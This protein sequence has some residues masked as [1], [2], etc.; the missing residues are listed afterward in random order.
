MQ[1][2]SYY[3]LVCVWSCTGHAQPYLAAN[4]LILG[5][6]SALLVQT[7][8]FDSETLMR[9]YFAGVEAFSEYLMLSV[10]TCARPKVSAGMTA[11]PNF[12]WCWGV[13]FVMRSFW[14]W[15]CVAIQ[16]LAYGAC[17]WCWPGPLK[18]SWLGFSEARTG[19]PTFLGDPIPS[20]FGLEALRV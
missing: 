4:I 10:S 16:G 2:G 12:T 17:R 14:G 9:T 7:K 8:G 13:C 11:L 5:C 15:H 1:G 6:L 18:I 19:S 20:K 3:S